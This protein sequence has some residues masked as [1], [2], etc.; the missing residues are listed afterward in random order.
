MSGESE[1]HDSAISP[2]VPT[3]VTFNPAAQLPLKLTPSNLA[4]RR[5]QLETLLLDLDLYGFIDGTTA[6]PVRTITENGATKPNPAFQLW[7]R[8]DKLILH[9][10][11]CSISESMYS[12]VSSASTSRTAWLILDKLYA[13]NAQSRIIRQNI[14]RRSGHLGVRE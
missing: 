12:F 1:V 2:A 4:S 13:S 14:Q 7:F 3:L 8:Q 11:R 5:S 9:A 6:A 10:L